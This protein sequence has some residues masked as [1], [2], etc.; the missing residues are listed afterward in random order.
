[1]P[2]IREEVEI[3]AAPEAVFD[4]IAN[5]EEFPRYVDFLREVKRVGPDRYRWTAEIVGVEWNW[6]SVITER[7]APE[8]IAWKSV[9]GL[10][11]SGCFTLKSTPEGTSVT[12]TMGFQIPGRLLE[13]ALAPILMPTVRKAAAR[14]MKQVKFVIETRAES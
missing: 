3:K 13:M 1:M 8:R 2:S 14:I 7:I 6:D 10:E 9:R 11:N 5:V 4:L 12:F